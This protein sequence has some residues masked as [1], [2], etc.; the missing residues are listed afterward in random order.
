V[1]PPSLPSLAV[2]RQTLPTGCLDT[3]WQLTESTPGAWGDVDAVELATQAREDSWLPAQ[4]PGTVAQALHFA[5]RYDPE[6]P[7]PL[8]DADFWYRATING[9]GQHMLE[10]S[11]LATLAEIYLD[12][13]LL[14]TSSS[15]FV[16]VRLPVQL[17]GHSVLHLA[18]RSLYAHLDDIKP[19]RARWRV[20]MIPR[21][22]LRAVRTTLLGHMPSWCPEIH[23]I[24][25]WLGMRLIPAGAI[26]DVRLR[27]SLL[28][29]TGTLN[30]AIQCRADLDGLRLSCAGVSGK[31]GPADGDYYR[32]TLTID[33]VPRWWPHGLG[34]PTLH[35]VILHLP[36]GPLTLGQVGF[37]RLELDRGDDGRGFGLTVNDRPLF[38]R[39]V[40]YTPADPL[41]PGGE[42]GLADRLCLLAE[43]GANLLRIAGPFCYESTEFFRQCDAL[44]LLVWQD[45]M[46]ANFDYPLTDPAF[47]ET[48]EGEVEA[49]LHRLSGSP[50]LAVLCGGSE[51]HQQASML[52]LPADRR[53]LA[54][55][56]QRLEQLCGRLIP[57]LI[58]VPNSPSGGT[59]PFDL[60]E[61]VSHYY[62]VGAYERP[63]EDAR[64]AAPRFITEC[65]AFANVPEPISL[66]ALDVA[67]VHHPTWK[68]GVPRDRG[69]SWDFE[70]T[71]DH[72]LERIFGLHPASLRRC[73]PAHYLAASRALAAHIIS[74]TLAE[75]RRPA[76]PT[77]GALVFTAGDLRP[78][79]GWGMIDA[80]G[81][82]KAPYYGFRQVAQPLSLF[83]TDEGCNGLDIHLV[84]DTAREFRLQLEVCALREGALPVAQ[85]SLVV[86]V[87]PS[88]GVTLEASQVLGH[89]FDLTYAFRFGPAGHD[90]VVVTARQADDVATPIF[91][92]ACH[93]PLGPYVPPEDI[94]L[95]ART[96][97]DD[98]MWWLEVTTASVARFVHIEDRTY[99]P[100]DNYFHLPPGRPRRIRLLPRTLGAGVPEG[101]VSALN[102]RHAVSYRGER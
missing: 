79:A 23:T 36:S 75:W 93:F 29:E 76:S 46:L 42:E 44:G 17:H 74:V 4:V 8:H 80:T 88:S 65:L 53:Q 14:A 100:E 94:D 10:L 5:G 57:E 48:L 22:S 54:F 20:A 62:G 11:G 26:E 96:L 49:L 34:E 68:A 51:I 7:R 72:Y 38:A 31:L 91:L 92:Q 13:H 3:D 89:F 21:Q 12:G 32:A 59:L 56:D 95:Q 85:G 97:A 33:Q 24:G 2:L 30:V 71:R 61:S 40:V 28:D 9:E 69:S 55:Y 78:G 19:P 43:M 63:L 6:Q 15:M 1:Q 27:T 73:D 47:V 77:R 98:G 87:P 41:H 25:P 35:E 50:S 64:R 101:R 99:R 67:A 37:R 39:G 45:L 83:L 16:P 81:E 66:E 58:V 102:A 82:P 18:F 86:D 60:R 90:S 52:G 70:D 84:N